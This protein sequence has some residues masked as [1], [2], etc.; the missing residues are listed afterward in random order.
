MRLFY[1]KGENFGDAL[2]P[3]IFQHLLPDFFDDNSD[4]LFVGIGSILGWVAPGKDCKRIIVFSSGFADGDASTYGNC[5]RLD[6][7][8]QILCVRGELTAQ[9]LGLPMSKAISDGALLLPKVVHSVNQDK[10]FDFAYMPHVGSLNVYNHWGKIT[11]SAGIHL[12]DPRM[13]PKLVIQEM[14][15]TKIL[16]T[17]AMHG[18]I[19]ADAYRIPWIPVKTIKT[20]NDFKWRDYL[21]TVGL[22]FHPNYL[23][24]PYSRKFL[25]GI[26]H[27]KLSKWKLG[28]MAPVAAVLYYLYQSIFVVPGIKKRFKQLKSLKTNLCSEEILEHRQSQLMSAIE[29]FRTAYKRK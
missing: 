17:E 6:D 3:I 1:Y 28:F 12:I 25:T 21:G 15:Q 9:K 11:A 13:D 23:R 7:R 8:Y 18:A 22:E 20:I 29:E 27:A 24:T 14:N 19:V 26:F 10:K 16:L 4:E 2:N 5:P